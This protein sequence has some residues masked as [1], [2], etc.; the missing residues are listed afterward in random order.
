MAL[1]I[2]CQLTRFMEV[3]SKISIHRAGIQ[4]GISLLNVLSEVV[5]GLHRVLCSFDQQ[6]RV[7]RG[8]FVV[9]QP[10]LHRPGFVITPS[11]V[12]VCRH[13]CLALLPVRLDGQL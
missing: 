8:G 7:G 12:G 9:G 10:V 5:G 2:S 13:T 6:S 3:L 11:V 4:Q 1:A